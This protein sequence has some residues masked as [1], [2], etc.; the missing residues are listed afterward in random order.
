MIYEHS[1]ED[2]GLNQRFQKLGHKEVPVGRNEAIIKFMDCRYIANS[3]Y[4]NFIK[5]WLIL[6][7]S[8]FEVHCSRS[9]MFIR[10]YI[11]MFCSFKKF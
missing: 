7:L 11:W 9:H 8:E 6:S 2:F 10:K 5:F 1:E 3:D 4:C